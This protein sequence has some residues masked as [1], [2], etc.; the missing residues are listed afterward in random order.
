MSKKVI[1]TDYKDDLLNSYLKDISKYKVLDTSEVAIL[2]SRA[3]QGDEAARNKVITSN[4]RFVVT[5]AK[6][7][8]NR[9]VPLM[10]LIAAGTEGLIK[11]VDKF[12]TTRGTVFLT[13]AG[14]WI[15]QCIYNTIY[16]H[17]E[18]IRLPISQRLIVIK[19]LDATNKFLQTHSRNPSVEELVELTG[20]DASQIDFL[21]QYSNKLLSID[22]FIGGDEEG[23][24]L[25]DVIPDEEAPLDDQINRKFVLSDLDNM[26]DT[27]SNREQDLLRMY[28]GIGMDPVDSK[29]ISEMFGVGKERI[30]QMK[31]TALRRLKKKFYHQLKGLV[32]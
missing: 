15:K 32:Q 3:Q 19:I 7:Y 18:E 11:S 4:L 22:D 14:W 9:G 2:I 20:V 27:L 13:Y 23:N 6:Q 16:A 1:F 12:D 17:G 29:T 26:L 30:R 10:D 5:I 28:F 24:Q 8:Q 31:E 21:S 25:C